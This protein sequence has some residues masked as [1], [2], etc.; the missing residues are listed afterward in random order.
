MSSVGC[1]FARVECGWPRLSHRVCKEEIACRL[2]W[3][4]LL[5]H[6]MVT[7]WS[8]EMVQEESGK[9][10]TGEKNLKEFLTNEHTT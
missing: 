3:A 9:D 4:D 8:Q 10:S 5:E 6:P 7:E 2:E 1:C